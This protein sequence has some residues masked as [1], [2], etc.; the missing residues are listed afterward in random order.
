[1]VKFLRASKKVKISKFIGWFCLKDKLLEQEI[2]IE[3]SR[4]GTEGPWKVWGKTKLWF[5]IQST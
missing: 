1:M 4:P 3:A 5:P 2:D